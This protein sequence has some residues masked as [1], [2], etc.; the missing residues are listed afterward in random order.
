MGAPGEGVAEEAGRGPGDEP[1]AA[2]AHP[3]AEEDENQVVHDLG[4]IAAASPPCPD[5]LRS[6]RLRSPRP[7]SILVGMQRRD[8]A[9]LAGT[10]LFK[11]IDVIELDALIGSAAA[12]VRE[13]GEGDLMLEALST[14]DALW[15]LV[16]GSV[17]A[18]MRG[19][20]GKTVRIEAIAAPAPLASAILFAPGSVLPVAVRALSS[21]RVVRL[22]REAVLTICQKSRAFLENYLRDSGFRIAALS[23]RFRLMQF[24]ALDER[25]ADWLLR[26]ADSAGGDSITLPSSKEELAETFGVT[27]PSLSRGFGELA[28]AGVIAVA[29]RSVRILD[30]KALEAI[31]SEG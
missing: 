5:R 30:R 4:R 9:A 26:Q 21:V 22:P 18:E 6:R 13:F 7:S 25:L 8:I 3:A 27:R 12:T 31:L 24:A 10:A 11:G 1:S 2:G 15:I 23:E 28:R 29:G 20:S 19:G 17:A 16:E 14:Y